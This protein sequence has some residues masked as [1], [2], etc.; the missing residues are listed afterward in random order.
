MFQTAVI[1][2]T[3]DYLWADYQLLPL[4]QE[5]LFTLLAERINQE[6]GGKVYGQQLLRQG[7]NYIQ[8]KKTDMPEAVGANILFTVH[9]EASCFY[10]VCG[11]DDVE[12]Q[13]IVSERYPET[14][15]LVAEYFDPETQHKMMEVIV[16]CSA[17][18]DAS[19]LPP[20][21]ATIQIRLQ[22]FQFEQDQTL[23][24]C[25]GRYVLPNHPASE[26]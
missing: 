6:I 8:V 14:K 24:K 16:D 10:P 17:V 19:L 13:V 1:Q 21:H 3:V 26:N 11:A 12:Y 5:P 20:M 7:A 9:C 18:S 22:D 23:V 2:I 4:D 25:L 15:E